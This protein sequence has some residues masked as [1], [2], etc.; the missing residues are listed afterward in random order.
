MQDYGFSHAVWLC[1]T[2]A[3]IVLSFAVFYLFPHPSS[4]KAPASV[5]SHRL[6][7]A[8]L[9]L[10]PQV[11]RSLL[12]QGLPLLRR[13]LGEDDPG[14]SQH[15]RPVDF[16]L[17]LVSEIRYPSPQEFIRVQIPLVDRQISSVRQDDHVQAQAVMARPAT[18][19][20]VPVP[21]PAKPRIFPERP[22]EPE[23]LIFH[24]HTSES[25]LPESGVDHK[26][27]KHGD[28]VKVG[29]FLAEQLESR[30]IPTLY[31]DEIHDMYPFRD[32]Y[33]RSHT[34]VARLL[35]ENPGI[36]MVLDIHRDGTPGLSCRKTI[37]GRAVAGIV[38]VVGTD[39]MGLEHPQ[40]QKNHQFA[41]E[42]AET[43]NRL[44]P[45][46]VLK[47]I[48]ADA[49]YNQHL[50]DKAIIVELGNQ[51][52]TLEEAKN[53]AIYLAEVIADYLR[54]TPESLRPLQGQRSPV[55]MLRALNNAGHKG[56]VR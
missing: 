34:T 15:Y 14:W 1:L 50:H 2:G 16:F 3:I 26:L 56:I 20:T 41:L 44:Y 35:Q 45:G 47:V 5:S 19:R 6:A 11:G 29:R 31:T 49:R 43:I 38:L 55:D 24:T 40:W 7:Q 52:S 10:D 13:H 18:D 8:F 17:R 25:Y 33:K 46:L 54:R 36:R 51:Y 9:N 32:S 12:Q 30:G 21:F 23:V 39:R 4:N 53:S 48:Q 27:N 37:A 22:V 42:L 28:I